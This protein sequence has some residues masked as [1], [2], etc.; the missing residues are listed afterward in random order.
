MELNRSSISNFLK[1]YYDDEHLLYAIANNFITHNLKT[2]QKITDWGSYVMAVIV[3]VS[4]LTDLTETFIEIYEEIKEIIKDEINMDDVNVQYD[5]IKESFDKFTENKDINIKII[6]GKGGTHHSSFRNITIDELFCR[7]CIKSATLKC[8][9]TGFGY[10]K[11]FENDGKLHRCNNY[12]LTNIV[13]LTPK[14][15][16]LNFIKIIKKIEG[17]TLSKVNEIR[18]DILQD[19]YN[20]QIMTDVTN[21]NYNIFGFRPFGWNL[22]SIIT[23]SNKNRLNKYKKILEKTNTDELDILVFDSLSKYNTN[24]YDQLPILFLKFCCD[25]YA[26]K[27][28]Y[29]Q[30]GQQKIMYVLFAY[31]YDQNYMPTFRKLK[32][33]ISLYDTKNNISINVPIEFGSDEL[34]KPED[35]KSFGY[36]NRTYNVINTNKLNDDIITKQDD[37]TK[38]NCSEQDNPEKCSII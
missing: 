4:R 37:F 7:Y 11:D 25:N 6:I 35:L 27:I 13:Y 33:D 2:Y 22:L 31:N 17:A 32:A 36:D 23:N 24:I 8:L 15:I 3:H 5:N 14:E 16:G 1:K 10:N 21:N 9:T 38:C 18:L 12:E 19:Y 29:T 30:N 26:S 28:K 20:N 34:C